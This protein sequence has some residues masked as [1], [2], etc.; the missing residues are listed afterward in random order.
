MLPSLNK[1]FIIIIIIIIII[2]TIIIIIIIIIIIVW[3]ERLYPFYNWNHHQHH[4]ATSVTL[5]AMM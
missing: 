4:R 1:V 5:N 3:P 2:I